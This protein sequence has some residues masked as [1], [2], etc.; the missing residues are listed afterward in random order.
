[1]SRDLG[2]GP[3]RAVE[4]VRHTGVRARNGF[5]H[6]TG[7]HFPTESP[8]PRLLVWQRDKARLYRYVSTVEPEDVLPTPILFVMSLVTTAKVFDLQE[9]NSLVRRFLDAGH[10]VYLLDWG[11]PDAVESQNT[12]ET[13]CDEYLPRAVRAA[14]EESGAEDI[15][16]FGYCLGAVMT[17]LSVAGHPAMP[18]RSIVLLA[19]PVDMG[20]LGPLTSMLRAGQIEVDDLVDW[21]GNVPADRIKESFHL[22]EPAGEITTY[23]SLWNSLGHPERLEAHQALV[24]W[25]SG[26]IPFPGAAFRQMV[27]LFIHRR[28]A[29]ARPGPAGSPGRRPGRHHGAGALGHGCPGQA[30]ARTVQRSAGAARRRAG[31]SRAQRRARGPD[32]GPARAQGDDPDDAGVAGGPVRRRRVTHRVLGTPRTWHS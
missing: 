17:M 22:V 11:V 28:H 13:Y 2:G 23:L 14:I 25:S 1:M 26:H 16:L 6:A 8:S 12:L 4:L 9:D 27:D 21:T 19:T 30:G 29:G 18:V 10:D 5:R 24:R 32:R 7:R 15:N 3:G 31:A 20:E